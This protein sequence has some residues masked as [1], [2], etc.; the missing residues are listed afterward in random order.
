MKK[1]EIYTNLDNQDFEINRYVSKMKPETS[2][3]DCM[4]LVISNNCSH[5]YLLTSKEVDE[6]CELLQNKKKE[7]WKE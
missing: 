7:I 3:S 2:Y 6:F 1:Q 4:E 5:F